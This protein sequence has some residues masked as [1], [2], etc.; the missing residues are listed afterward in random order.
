MIRIACR[1]LEAWQELKKIFPKQQQ[2]DGAKRIAV[3][4]DI[5]ANTSTSFQYFVSG[6]KRFA[7]GV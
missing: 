2:I 4:M 1:E 7:S 3:H 5:E 6:V